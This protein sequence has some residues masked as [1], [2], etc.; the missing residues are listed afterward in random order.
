VVFF[1]GILFSGIFFSVVLEIVFC[2]ALALALSLEAGLTTFADPVFLATP[3]LTTGVLPAG[4]LA[5]AFLAGAFLAGAFLA[6]T[7]LAGCA[8]VAFFAAEGFAALRDA[9]AGILGFF[10]ADLADGL[11]LAVF[12][13][14]VLEVVFFATL[15]RSVF[16]RPYQLRRICS[17]AVFLSNACNQDP[18]LNFPF[19]L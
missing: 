12:A 5:G 15:K 9:L 8:F 14:F 7:F 19:E 18:K 2:G 10:A 4:F 13:A 3:F 1:S 17:T 11:A 6:G 16:S